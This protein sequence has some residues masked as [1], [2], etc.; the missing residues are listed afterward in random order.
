VQLPVLSIVCPIG[1]GFRN[2]QYLYEW[3]VEAEGREVEVILVLDNASLGTIGI[4]TNLELI[5]RKLKV[6]KGDFNSPGL[7]RNHGMA[8]ASGEWLAFWDSDD[9]PNI[10]TFIRMV[11]ETEKSGK[12]LGCGRFSTFEI[13]G[14]NEINSIRRSAIGSNLKSELLN[15]GIW[16]FCFRRDR[17]QGFAFPPQIMGEDQVFLAQALS[18]SKVHNFEE[19]V[20]EYQTNSS[21]QL[22]SGKINAKDLNRS[23]KNLIQIY[24]H[25]KGEHREL[26]AVLFANMFLSAKLRSNFRDT[27]K[28]FFQSAV[29]WFKVGPSKKLILLKTFI[30]VVVKKLN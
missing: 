27:L 5:T 20:Y 1:P 12:L 11:T 18:L 23:V 26:V 24:S 28:L 7:A 3:T 14:S 15:P 13:S 25:S 29:A 21:G 9:K 10:E 30:F 2:L 16:R 19:V 8:H 17:L 6:L 4:I 22:T